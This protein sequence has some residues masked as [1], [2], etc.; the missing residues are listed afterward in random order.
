MRAVFHRGYWLVTSLYLV[1]DANLS[2]FQLLFIGTAQGLTALAFEIPTGVMADTISRKW[3]IVMAQLVMGTGID[4]YRHVGRRV[5]Y[6]L[7]R[8]RGDADVVGARVD[9]LERRRRRVAHR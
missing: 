2:A 7:P 5:R 6:F 8:A 3:S 1:V 4:G 9:V